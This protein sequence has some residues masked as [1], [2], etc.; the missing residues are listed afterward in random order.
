MIMSATPASQEGREGPS[1]ATAGARAHLDAA[2]SWWY[3]LACARRV[4]LSSTRLAAAAVC[5]MS[6]AAEALQSLPASDRGRRVEP[7]PLC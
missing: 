5:C 3:G 4:V 7:P 6:F 1:A 2:S